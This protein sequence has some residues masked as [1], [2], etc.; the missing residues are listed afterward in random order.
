M[1][2]ALGILA[3]IVAFVWAT[4]TLEALR[5]LPG[6]P[7]VL[8]VEY[9][10]PLSDPPLISVIVPARDEAADIEATLRSLLAVEG[11]RLEILA[12]DDRS[13]DTTGAIM[14]RIAAEAAAEGKTLLALHIRELPDGWMGKTHAMAYAARHAT[15][16]WLLFTDG[17]IL[18]AKDSLLRAINFAERERADHAIIFPTLILKTFGE[19]MLMA[20]FQGLSALF[21]RVW[22]IPV[23]GRKESLGVGAFNL[24]RAA[25][26]RELG[27]FESLR[28]EVLEDL[29]LG[30]EVKRHGYRQRVA[31]GR[32]LVRVRWARGVAGTI[33][34]IT[35]NCFA[36]FRFRVWMT[37]AVCA[38]LAIFCLGPFAAIAGNWW[39]RTSTIV[40]LLMLLLLYR[41]YRQ[42]T[43]I[44]TWY[45]FTFPIA[46]CLVLYAILRSMVITLARG[47]V[48]WRGT[49]YP[50]AELR[51]N[52]GPLL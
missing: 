28:M 3:W 32:D 15:G 19:R 14:D 26:Y 27:G 21:S 49:L 5:K 30:F 35:K 20:F 36:L 37:L 11:I 1:V 23:E 47:G 44:A 40:V 22:N 52:A 34:N 46:A 48:V 17:D 12:V 13:T 18:F 50:L 42:Y 25:V 10:S 31:F 39:M 43:G 9:A 45:A 29:R 41:Y 8:S 33:R 51:K 24:I 38:G 4:N 6:I 7:D 2:L 16:E